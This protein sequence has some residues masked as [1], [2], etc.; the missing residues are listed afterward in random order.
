M[1][2]ILIFGKNGQLGQELKQILNSSGQ[3]I[4]AVGRKEIDLTEKEKLPQLIEQIQ[5]KIIINAAAYTAV[6][7]AETE[8]ELAY[9]VNADAPQIIA[10]VAQELQAFLIHVSTDYVFDG[11]KSSPYQETDLTKPIN[12]YGE[13]K[14]AGEEAIKSAC[15][16][17][18][19]LRTAWVYGNEGKGN[20]V[21]T[22]LKLG[23]ARDEIR[24][25]A[26]QIGSPTW[27]R[28]LASAI[29]NFIPH[30]N[31]AIS[32][33]YHYTN[34]GI[35]SWYDFAV[36]IFAEA[37]KLNLP[38]QVQRVIPITTLEYPTPA[39]RPAYSVLNCAK[40]QQV[41]GTYPPHW[42]QSLTEMLKQE[43]KAKN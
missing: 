2:P 7:K 27:T 14:L 8:V 16:N 40:I 24:V 5:P 36:A 4:I 19:I 6:D 15:E 10:Q 30:L 37:K 39:K 28:D 34:S 21:K 11:R 23:A 42:R 12:V 17:Y 1:K 3:K 35:A 33:I 26:D 38:L 31:P 32:G 13:S 43:L 41:L 22:M 20:F 25:V 18:L 29:A 9:K